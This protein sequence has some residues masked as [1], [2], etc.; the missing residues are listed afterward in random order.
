MFGINVSLFTPP[1]PEEEKI[2]KAFL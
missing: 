1:S 2:I